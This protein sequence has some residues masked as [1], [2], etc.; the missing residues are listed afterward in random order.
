MDVNPA[1]AKYSATHEGRTYYFC[2]GAARGKFKAN[3]AQYLKSDDVTPVGAEGTIYTCPCTPS[4]AGRPRLLPDLR[5]GPRT[6][7]ALGR[8][9]TIRRAHRHDAALLWPRFSPSRLSSSAWAQNSTTASL[10]FET[11]LNWLR[12]KSL[13]RPWSFGRL[14]VLRARYRSIKNRSLNMFTLIAMGV[15]VAWLYSVV[16]TAPQLFPRR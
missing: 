5:Y 2:S 7:N 12:L 16:A 3:P 6:R 9:R 13:P 4:P 14:A 11:W 15:G 1:T 8:D 10:C